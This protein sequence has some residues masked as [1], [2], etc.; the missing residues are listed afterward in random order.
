M[1]V[2]IKK[3]SITIWDTGIQVHTRDTHSEELSDFS[4]VVRIKLDQLHKVMV[5]ITCTGKWNEQKITI[6]ILNN[7]PT[8]TKQHVYIIIR[9]IDYNVNIHYID[10]ALKNN[11]NKF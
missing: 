5:Y 8:K 6:I 1:S 11:N 7:I 3:N 9:E 10:R 4:T 2:T